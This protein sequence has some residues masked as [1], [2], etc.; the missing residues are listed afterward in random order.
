MHCEIDL[1]PKFV[2]N[3]KEL[4]NIKNINKSMQNI[5]AP[6]R[7]CNSF[8]SSLLYL[9]GKKCR[10]KVNLLPKSFTKSFTDQIFTDFFC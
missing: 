5:I 1:K 2:G 10:Q 8:S 3:M 4:Q 7:S 9:I 6:T